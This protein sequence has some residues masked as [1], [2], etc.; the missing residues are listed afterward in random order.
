MAVRNAVEN[1]TE[2]RQDEGQAC[3]RAV[4][5]G[6]KSGSALPKYHENRKMHIESR[7]RVTEARREVK[8]QVPPPGQRA[9]TQNRTSVPAPEREIVERDNQMKTKERSCEIGGLYASVG[10]QGL[11]IRLTSAR[12][13]RQALFLHE[14][15]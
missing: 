5:L 14:S 3:T 10:Q 15:A 7:S 4:I 12:R 11:T 9:K 2:G 1:E 6:R 8:S 13:T